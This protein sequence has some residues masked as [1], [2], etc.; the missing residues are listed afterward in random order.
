M[1]VGETIEE[2]APIPGYDGRY[3]AST[4]GNI[5]S[6]LLGGR[7]LKQNEHSRGYLVV[8]LWGTGSIKKKKEFVHRLVAL[9]HI[10]NSDGLNI[11]NHKNMNKQENHIG[12]LEWMNCSQNTQHYFDNKPF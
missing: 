8:W 11:V 5:R 9:A 10:P 1:D 6:L 3:E 12:N 4:H 7:I 2:W